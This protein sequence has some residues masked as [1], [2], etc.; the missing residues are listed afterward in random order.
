[1]SH[2]YVFRYILV[3]DSNV[4]KSCILSRFI[5]EDFDEI[6]NV[7]I[8]VEFGTRV[9]KTSD[10]GIKIHIWD[11]AG[12][13]CFRSITRAYYRDAAG[14][15]IVYDITKKESFQNIKLWFDE[16]MH[17]ADD[18]TIILVGNKCD[19][20]NLREVDTNEGQKLANEYQID[21]MEV[22]AKKNHKI[23]NIF[24]KI[25]D[26]IIKKIDDMDYMDDEFPKGIKLNLGLNDNL[27]ETS[28]VIKLNDSTQK[29]CSCC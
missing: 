22:S 7:T 24:Y 27:N 3:G 12:Q 29:I 18:P 28:K 11:T 25:T 2:D 23:N 14:V 19:L 6:H 26:S 10:K 4:G 1:M 17:L 9:I 21:F 5:N 15:I 13:E 8:G 20:N 16:V